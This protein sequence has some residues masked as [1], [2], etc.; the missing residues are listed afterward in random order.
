MCWRC[1]RRGANRA[2][3][4]AARPV[5]KKS[6]TTRGVNICDSQIWTPF[7]KSKKLMSIYLCSSVHLQNSLSQNGDWCWCWSVIPLVLPVEHI[8]P[9][10]F[11]YVYLKSL[12][13]PQ[14][15]I[16]TCLV[17]VCWDSC[18]FLKCCSAF[19]RAAAVR[20]VSL[21][22][23]CCCVNLL[24]VLLILLTCS[25]ASSATH[26]QPTSLTALSA[27]FC[28]NPSMFQFIFRCASIS[29]IGYERGVHY[30]SGAN[31]SWDIGTIN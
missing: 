14:S 25:P 22:T 23:H 3:T 10:C 13:I 15:R 5:G 29:W 21:Q 8:R 26:T 6:H 20:Q 4:H 31:F 19:V 28:V 27:Q 2:P 24:L 7:I 1:G 12:S 18:D 30:F 16:R 11:P 17:L 9:W